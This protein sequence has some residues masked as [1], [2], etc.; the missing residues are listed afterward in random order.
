MDPFDIA[1][2]GREEVAASTFA[3]RFERPKAFAFAAGQ[4]IDLSLTDPATPG[5][6]MKHA[7]SLA[8]APGEGELTIATRLRDTPFKRTL[9]ALPLGAR[10]Q[11]E[12][13]FGELA[14]DADAARPAVLLAGGIGITPFRSMLRQS[15]QEIA[16][17]RLV[18]FY[19]NRRPE[20]AAFLGELQELERRSPRFTLVAT[21]TQVERSSQ[22][23]QGETGKIS[24][25]LLARH[26]GDLTA[27]I[28]YLA[29]PPG[30]V[31]GLRDVLRAAGIGQEALKSE[32]FYGY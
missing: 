28:Y 17:P 27:P 23:W 25:A 12:G 19:S 14:L 24:S 2:L 29:G 22:P 31:A 11:I 4:S 6:V 26:L 32:E 5:T 15:L 20:D 7:F 1:L 9:R 18:L 13:P 8:G 3:F 30:L 10:V 21:M 16:G